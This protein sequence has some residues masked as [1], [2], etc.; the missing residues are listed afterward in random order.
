MLE[1]T[2]LSP[3]APPIPD[4]ED[5]CEFLSADTLVFDHYGPRVLGLGPLARQNAARGPVSIQK[6]IS[7]MRS[8]LKR[9]TPSPF[10]LPNRSLD[11]TALKT[12]VGSRSH[13]KR[14]G[15][16]EANKLD[17]TA[18]EESIYDDFVRLLRAFPREQGMELMK[19][20]QRDADL[21]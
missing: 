2:D 15:R 10:S 6:H 12:L 19:M 13:V 8:S 5:S 16:P 7:E 9:R 11:L 18:E 21:T 14:Q 20:A 1:E 3:K 17:L 4:P